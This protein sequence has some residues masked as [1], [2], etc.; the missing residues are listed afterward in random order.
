MRA[1]A[2]DNPNALTGRYNH[3]LAPLLTPR[4]IALVGASPRPGSIGNATARAL[5]ASGFNGSVTFVNSRHSEVEGRLC[6]ADLSELEAPPDLAILN[7][8]AARIEDALR[9]VIDGGARSAVIFDACH[10]ET[11][12]GEPLL[13]RLRSMACD[14]GIPVCG[15]NGMGFFNLTDRIHASFYGAGH[16]KPGGISLIAHS[17]SVFT[18]LG[19]NDPR[20]RFD[21]MISPGQEIGATIDEYVDFAVSRATTTV[22]AL[23]M[24]QARD[25]AAFIAALERAQQSGTPVVVCKVGRSAESARLAHSHSGAM[26]GSADGYDA[27]LERYGAVSVDTVDQLM[28]TA[29][30]LTSGRTMGDGEC[31]MVTD[32]GGLRELFIDRAGN[33]GVP[34]ARLT[35]ETKERLAAVLP[36]NLPPSNPL[37]CAGAVNDDFATVFRRGLEVLGDAP[38]VAC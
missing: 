18:V 15:G 27:V 1:T 32:S 29:M 23:F 22:V 33:R 35:D 20:Y 38:E 21:L 37:D 4:S 17:G 19:L 9:Q 14:A 31:A 36:P 16:L 8:G 5:L 28:N 30:L 10:G 7:V 2:P 25:P 11:A 24:E 12:T 3:Q 26:V 34:V 6:V 13:K